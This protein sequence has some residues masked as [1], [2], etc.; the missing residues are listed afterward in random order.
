MR[1]LRSVQHKFC[2]DGSYMKEYVL[3]EPVS[4]GFFEYL[5][6]FGRV[7]EMEN[8][9]SGFYKFEKRDFFSI[10]GFAG[11]ISVEVRFKAEVMDMTSSFL[12]FLFS[13]FKGEES[14]IAALKKREASLVKRVKEQLYGKL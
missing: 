2:A 5:K 10:K 13:Q 9:G 11:E 6:Y 3:D 14:D 7:E 8:L 12:L 4:K 1:I